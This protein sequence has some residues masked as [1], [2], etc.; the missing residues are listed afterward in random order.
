MN[1]A[2]TFAFLA[3]VTRARAAFTR[4]LQHAPSQNN[5][6]GPSLTPLRHA[7]YR[8]HIADHRLEATR[9]QPALR[10]DQFPRRKAGRRHSPR[11][12]DS[13]SPAQRFEHLAQFGPVLWSIFEHA[14][15]RSGEAPLLI[16]YVR[17]GGFVCSHS[18]KLPSLA[19]SA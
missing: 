19:E 2:V 3:V 14:R 1:L 11:F 8:A 15:V 13:R 5:R 17:R 18:A 9:I 7:Q 12:T 10:L 4:G 16:R 6:T